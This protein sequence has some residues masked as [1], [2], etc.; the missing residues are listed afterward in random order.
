VDK[1]SHPGLC[2]Q[3]LLKS[4]LYNVFC[5]DLN[6]GTLFQA[7]L[8]LILGRNLTFH[9]PSSATFLGLSQFPSPGSPNRSVNTDN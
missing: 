8:F 4:H 5:S 1:C 6:Q 3:Q 2:T 7:L 9:L